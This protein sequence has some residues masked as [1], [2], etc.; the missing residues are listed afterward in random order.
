MQPGRATTP[1]VLRALGLHLP[2]PGRLRH[3]WSLVQKSPA[4]AGEN[5]THRDTSRVAAQWEQTTWTLY[6]LSFNA[7][8]QNP[9]HANCARIISFQR[10]PVSRRRR[11]LQAARFSRR[12]AVKFL[13]LVTSAALLAPC[14]GAIRQT[15]PTNEASSTSALSLAASVTLCSSLPS[16]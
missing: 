5:G 8:S 13:S 10:R 9:K 11:P 4:K 14:L 1:P 12:S 2:A 6:R 15:P 7:E 16:P 3:P